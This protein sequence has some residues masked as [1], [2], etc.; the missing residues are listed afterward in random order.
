MTT[1]TG[2]KQPPTSDGVPLLGNGL[3]FSRDPFDAVVKWARK[4]DVVHLNFPGRSLYMVTEPS[5]IEQ[6]LVANQDAFTIGQ[7]QRETFSG[8]EDDAVTA[9]TGDH[10]KRLRKGLHPAFTWDGIQGYGTRMAERT[11]DHVDRWEAGDRLDLLA[12]M[13]LLTL[14]ILGDTLLGGSIEGDEEVVIDAADALV[15]RADPRRFGQLLP[16]WVPTPTQRRFVRAVGKLDDYVADVLAECSPGGGD[17]GSVLL[18]A[19][20]RGDLSMAEVQDNLTAL[21]LTGHDS[22]AVTLTYAWYELSRHPTLRESLA[23]EAETVVGRVP[24]G[25]SFRRTPADTERRQGNTPV[26]PIHVGSKSRGD[27]N[28]RARRVRDSCGHA[29]DDSAVGASPGRSVLGGA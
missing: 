8:I 12:E 20:E 24:R 1:D 22:T 19:H 27:R 9:N 14:R 13:R 5:L 2:M 3:A 7:Q 23:D 16:D 10:W 17:V 25:C 18:A 21:L 29:G 28:D 15:E 6:V 4:G 26:V 11:A